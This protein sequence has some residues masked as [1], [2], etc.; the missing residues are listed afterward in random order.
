MNEK[1][2]RSFAAF[3]AMALLVGAIVFAIRRG[4][5]GDDTNISTYRVPAQPSPPP[6]HRIESAQSLAALAESHFAARRFNE[7]AETY[8][9]I[10]ALSPQ[11]AS[12]HTD[13]G[14]ALH[15]SGRSP[16][17]LDALKTATR[18]DSRLQRAGLSYGY[19]LMSM[20]KERQARDVLK[21]TVALDPSSPQ[22]MEAKN[23]LNR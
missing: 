17:A 2:K 10:A 16:E 1:S 4:L 20:G 12:V 11:D 19:V 6:V 14:L 21:K 22:G 8:R 5:S 15:Y 23:M 18:L 3:V 9:K 7:A 13:L